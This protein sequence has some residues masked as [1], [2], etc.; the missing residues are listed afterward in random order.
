[1]SLEI[2]PLAALYPPT[3]HSKNVLYRAWIFA[4]SGRKGR[5]SHAY[6]ICAPFYCI[7]LKI[8]YGE[9][10]NAARGLISRDMAKYKTFFLQDF[11][12]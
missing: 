8:I 5:Y 6:D 1:M 7:S 11:C 10:Y 12:F 2:R 9:V 4:V 3:P